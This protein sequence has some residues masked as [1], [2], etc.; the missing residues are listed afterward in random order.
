MMDR[1]TLLGYIAVLTF[2]AVMFSVRIAPAHDNKRPELNAWFSGLQSRH[3]IACCDGTDAQRLD[4]VD[5]ESKD[6]HYRVRLRNEW[7][8]VPDS[9]V[10]DGPNQAGPTMVWPYYLN[11]ELRGVRC[12]IPG[13]MG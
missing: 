2:I 10:I 12:F 7:V 8:D 5:W 13:S 9:A 1:Y 3:K 4:D 11:G 6:G